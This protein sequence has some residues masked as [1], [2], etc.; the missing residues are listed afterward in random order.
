MFS[1]SLMASPLA[2]TFKGSNKKTGGRQDVEIMPNIN[3][4]LQIAGSAKFITTDDCRTGYYP[5]LS[6]SRVLVLNA[7]FAEFLFFYLSF[8]Y[9]HS[10]CC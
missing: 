6:M 4:L 9:I 1:T 7:P 10:E 3:D 8:S 5:L 2:C